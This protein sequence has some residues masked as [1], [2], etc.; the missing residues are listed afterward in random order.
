MITNSKRNSQPNQTKKNN[1][2][3]YHQ[4]G[5]CIESGD[6][7][8]TYDQS[9]D[10]ITKN[11]KRNSQDRGHHAANH[12]KNYEKTSLQEGQHIELGYQNE[13]YDQSENLI[14]N[15]RR[16][17]QDYIDDHHAGNPSKKNNEKTFRKEGDRRQ[18]CDQHK[19]GQQPNENKKDFIQNA[20]SIVTTQRNVFTTFT[21]P[22]SNDS[23]DKQ[24]EMLDK[25]A[26]KST[27]KKKPVSSRIDTPRSPAYPNESNDFGDLCFG[28]PGPVEESL[29]LLTTEEQKG[30]TESNKLPKA[31]PFEY[32]CFSCEFQTNNGDEYFCHVK[33]VHQPHVYKGASK[34]DNELERY[35]KEG[36]KPTVYKFNKKV[37]DMELKEVIIP[38]NGFCFVSSVLITL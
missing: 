9:E 16:S 17:S 35:F 21:S 2:K 22:T 36:N 37:N 5:K 38:G 18:S 15:L 14:T 25:K 13:T 32:P 23:L 8:K 34:E 26:T 27:S 28:P 33:E 24:K 6:Q 4:D 3:N 10:F 19:N 11:S 7:N 31:I 29:S 30:S 20:S 12:Q 1:K